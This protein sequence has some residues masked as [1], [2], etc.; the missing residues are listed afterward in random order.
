MAYIKFYLVLSLISLGYIS[1]AD[2]DVIRLGVS[3]NQCIKQACNTTANVRKYIFEQAGYTV[4]TTV[5]PAKRLLRALLD[6]TVDVIAH[7]PATMSQQAPQK[8]IHSKY[9]NSF[10]TLT[11][12]YKE[13]DFWQP[14]WPPQPDFKSKAK[15]VMLNDT[16]KNS[17]GMNVTQVNSIA[18][19]LK[20]VEFNRADYFL[21]TYAIAPSLASKQIINQVLYRFWTSAIFAN[22][23]R[24]QALEQ[25]YTRGF[26][27]IVT[28]TTKY[29]E[30]FLQNIQQDDSEFHQQRLDYF[31][32]QY[33]QRYPALFGGTAFSCGNTTCAELLIGEKCCSNVADAENLRASKTGICGIDLVTVAGADFQNMCFETGLQGIIDSDCPDRTY[34]MN[35]Q[36]QGCCATQLSRATGR[37]PMICGTQNLLLGM[38]CHVGTY[39]TGEIND[40]PQGATF[41]DC[42]GNWIDD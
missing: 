9:A 31:I 18:A 6:N 28:N 21:T 23:K 34:G 36:E 38:G 26:E 40:R 4:K 11:I 3:K 30:L 14:S 13:S 29:A 1:H 41:L 12:Y 35:I 24:G 17:V 2:D 19:G 7:S 25:T 20:M 27:K 5:L 10:T 15:G 42:D 22:N 39:L 8:T 33:R 37:K 32:A 16:F